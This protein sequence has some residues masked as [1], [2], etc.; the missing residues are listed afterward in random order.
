MKINDINVGQSLYN[1]LTSVSIE[2]TGL[3]SAYFAEKKKIEASIR[4]ATE[5]ELFISSRNV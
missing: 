2:R 3:I 4:K 5:S 1:K